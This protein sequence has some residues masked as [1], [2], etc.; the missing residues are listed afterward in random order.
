[1]KKRS[2]I[3][4]KKSKKLFSKTAKKTNKKNLNTPNPMR[5]GIRL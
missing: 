3:P 5:G 2:K 4:M 1:M